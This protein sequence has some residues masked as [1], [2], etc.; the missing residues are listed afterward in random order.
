MKARLIRDCRAKIQYQKKSLTGTFFF[1]R[2]AMTNE[3]INEL[4]DRSGEERGK[5]GENNEQRL[6]N[7]W[8]NFTSSPYK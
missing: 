1:S 4:K 6:R 7:I 8:D 3:I 5:I 2:M